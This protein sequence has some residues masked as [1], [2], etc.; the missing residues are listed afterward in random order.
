MYAK[1]IAHNLRPVF[2]NMSW[3]PGVNIVP[4]GKGSPL[5]S[6]PPHP[7]VNTLL[8][9]NRRVKGRKEDPHP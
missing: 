2:N 7:R 4:Y 1:S 3:P 6:P 5:R 8:C 9:L